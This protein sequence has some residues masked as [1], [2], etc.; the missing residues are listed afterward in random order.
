[1]IYL[2]IDYFLI[3]RSIYLNESTLVF[4]PFI[5]LRIDRCMLKT[6]NGHCSKQLKAKRYYNSYPHIHCTK[7]CAAFAKHGR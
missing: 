6:T 1:M 5:L 3:K 7:Q 4:T 2:L